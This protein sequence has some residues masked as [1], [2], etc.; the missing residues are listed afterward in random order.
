MSLIYGRSNEEFFFFA[1]LYIGSV[2]IE[3]GRFINITYVIKEKQHPLLLYFFHSQTNF[4]YVYLF[5][6][7]TNMPK[8][9]KSKL[10]YFV[11]K[12]TSLS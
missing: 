11:K 4:K 2:L 1:K 7:T 3:P 10:K 8:V 9:L 6:R 5:I 12:T